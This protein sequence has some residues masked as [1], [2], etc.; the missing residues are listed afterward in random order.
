MVVQNMLNYEFKRNLNDVVIESNGTSIH[1]VVISVAHF[2]ISLGHSS[3]P[4]SEDS[5]DRM[6]PSL[7]RPKFSFEIFEESIVLVFSSV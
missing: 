3:S 1:K 2:D 6:L 7:V 5:T 4:I